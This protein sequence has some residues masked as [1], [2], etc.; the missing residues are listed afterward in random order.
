MVIII[1]N[2]NKNYFDTIRKIEFVQLHEQIYFKIIQNKYIIYLLYIRPQMSIFDVN[3]KIVLEN[4]VPLN[5]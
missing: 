4:V 1:I 3:I 2:G 5:F